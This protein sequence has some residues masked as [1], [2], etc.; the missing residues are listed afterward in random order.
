MAE[1]SL[2]A[3]EGGRMTESLILSFVLLAGLLAFWAWVWRK[4]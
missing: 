1:H 4:K 3:D 2:P